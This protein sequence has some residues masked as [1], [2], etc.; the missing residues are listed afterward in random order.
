MSFEVERDGNPAPPEVCEWFPQSN[1]YAHT[2][3]V[4]FLSPGTYAIVVRVDREETLER[5][6]TLVGAPDLST[7]TPEEMLAMAER[8][9][10]L[11]NARAKSEAPTCA[12]VCPCATGEEGQ[13]KGVGE[14]CEPWKGRRAK[15]M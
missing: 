10:A 14:L 4:R 15:R 8:D 9:E 2:V 6:S 7:L 5:R 3:T 13:G 12:R 1:G 11:A